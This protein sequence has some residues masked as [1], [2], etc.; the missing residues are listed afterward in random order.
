MNGMLG[1][2]WVTHRRQSSGKVGTVGLGL[3]KAWLRVIAGC[4]RSGEGLPCAP[5][6]PTLVHSM[7]GPRRSQCPCPCPPSHLSCIHTV[8]APEGTSVQGRPSQGVDH[9]K[10]KAAA[11]PFPSLYTKGGL[12]LSEAGSRSPCW[13]EGPA[14]ILHL[15]QA[16][17]ITTANGS[18]QPPPAAPSLTGDHYRQHQ[19]HSPRGSFSF[20]PSTSSILGRN[21]QCSPLKDF[22]QTRPGPA[23]SLSSSSLPF[24]EH[25][26]SGC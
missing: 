25:G 15:P 18:P 16:S 12:P 10:L 23:P 22:L 13:S 17:L 19:A 7:P 11:H 20:S 3:G 24:F 26:C 9:A 5:H 4:G 8:C 2:N 1:R 21:P 6:Q 14:P